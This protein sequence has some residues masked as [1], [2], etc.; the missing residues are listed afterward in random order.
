MGLKT[1]GLLSG[2]VALAL[3]APAEQV[4]PLRAVNPRDD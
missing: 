2:L 3:L 4:P 1:A